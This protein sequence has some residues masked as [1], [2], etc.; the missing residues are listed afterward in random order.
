MVEVIDAIDFKYDCPDCPEGQ[1]KQLRFA[2]VAA[3]IDG[4]PHHVAVRYK[5]PNGH[6]RS[7][8]CPKVTRAAVASIEQKYADTGV[9]RVP[10]WF[11]PQD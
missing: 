10:V 2:N 8:K 1:R 4:D 6:E 11:I 5:C 7:V 3:K 9:D